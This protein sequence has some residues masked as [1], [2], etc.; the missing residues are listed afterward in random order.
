M[1]LVPFKPKRS[2]NGSFPLKDFIETCGA[3]GMWEIVMNNPCYADKDTGCL[4]VK[5]GEK[6]VRIQGV[7]LPKAQIYV[8]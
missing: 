3:R 8:S 2:K 5:R 4:Y 6:M 1:N 7:C